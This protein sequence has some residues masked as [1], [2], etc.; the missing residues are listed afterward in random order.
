MEVDSINSTDTDQSTENND[1]PSPIE[2]APPSDSTDTFQAA[3]SVNPSPLIERDWSMQWLLQKPERIE[4]TAE[5][6]KRMDPDVTPGYILATGDSA[7]KAPKFI[8]Y[9]QFDP[10]VNPDPGLI[11]YQLKTGEKLAVFEQIT[12]S[13]FRQVKADADKWA[14]INQSQSNQYVLVG[15]DQTLP[16]QFGDYKQFDPVPGGDPSIIQYQLKSGQKAVVSKDL[17][18]KFFEQVKQAAD[19]WGLINAKQKQ[20][21]KVIGSDVTTAPKREDYNTIR[22]LGQHD[23]LLQYET[24]EGK[25]VVAKELNPEMY[26][27][28]LSALEPPYTIHDFKELKAVVDDI[29]DP[30]KQQDQAELIKRQDAATHFAQ[31]LG[32][33]PDILLEDKDRAAGFIDHAGGQIDVKRLQGV[34]G[35]NY[36]QGI[37]AALSAQIN[38]IGPQDIAVKL[39]GYYQQDKAGSTAMGTLGWTLVAFDQLGSN[40]Q[41]LPKEWAAALTAQHYKNGVFDLSILQP[42]QR[43]AFKTAAVL[44]MK[45]TLGVSVEGGDPI[46][47][48]ALLV[49]E[50]VKRYSKALGS[51]LGLEKTDVSVLKPYEEKVFIQDDTLRSY[52]TVGRYAA[53]QLRKAGIK[54]K[55][56]SE[57]PDL[58]KALPT[59]T[60]TEYF[61]SDGRPSNEFSTSEY[62]WA[63]REEAERKISE[64]PEWAFEGLRGERSRTFD[65]SLAASR[66]VTDDKQTT[67]LKTVAETLTLYQQASTDGRL[68]RYNADGTLATPGILPLMARYAQSTQFEK[69]ELI[70]EESPEFEKA[71]AQQIMQVYPGTY[72]PDGAGGYNNISV[73]ADGTGGIVPDAK[74]WWRVSPK[75]DVTGKTD[76]DVL[77]AWLQSSGM[78]ADDIVQKAMSGM[79][80]SKEPGKG[81]E[82]TVAE[83]TVGLATGA[84]FGPIGWV[85]GALIMAGINLIENIRHN[86]QQGAFAKWAEMQLTLAGRDPYWAQQNLEANT[87]TAGEIAGAFFKDFAMDFALNVAGE[88]ILG[89]VLSKLGSGVKQAAEQGLM[90]LRPGI[91]NE[92]RNAPL[93]MPAIANPTSKLPLDN[94]NALGLYK[95]EATL[96][97]S[98][99]VVTYVRPAQNGLPATETKVVGKRVPGQQDRFEVKSL[100]TGETVATLKRMPTEDGKFVWMDVE[101]HGLKGGGSG[102]SK[103][104]E[105]LPQP[106][107]ATEERP[108][109]G[110][111]V[112]DR[113]DVANLSVEDSL[114]NTLKKQGVDVPAQEDLSF[115]REIDE[116]I[117]FLDQAGR[118]RIIG[119]GWSSEQKEILDS[120]LNGI[121]HFPESEIRL[122]YPDRYMEYTYDAYNESFGSVD[123]YHAYFFFDEGGRITGVEVRSE[124]AGYA[125]VAKANDSGNTGGLPAAGATEGDLVTRSRA[126]N[127]PV[128]DTDYRASF[129]ERERF[130]QLFLEGKIKLDKEKYLSPDQADE[131]YDSYASKMEELKDTRYQYAGIPTD[132]LVALRTY[133]VYADELNNA[134][135]RGDLAKL[136]ELDPYIKTLVSGL[137]RLPPYRMYR[138]SPLYK[139]ATLTA[140][141]IKAYIPGE[142]ITEP[143]FFSTSYSESKAHKKNVQYQVYSQ[144]GRS[145]TD[146]SLYQDWEAE[147]LLRPG[148]KFK[149]S[150]VVKR[151]G[152]SYEY[153]DAIIVL[154]E[155]V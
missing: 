36:R 51:D 115:I 90:K 24:K 107:E 16:P 48:N 119:D 145:L 68:K 82:T 97:Y 130:R 61:I 26:K 5:T 155:V 131:L 22:P 71:N 86:E 62:K 93:H 85:A 83:W 70:G 65:A 104:Q 129:E 95:P 147:V 138:N 114:I 91:A 33:D 144:N 12:P 23:N 13:L 154:D 7:D 89:P 63:T 44:F 18:A 99:E 92:L 121:S 4:S 102:S 29:H 3:N 72:V 124:F 39:Q 146:I 135:K 52:M 103:P 47:R 73:I 108:S 123:T 8:D 113:V 53:D 118:D 55:D 50:A 42:E 30:V 152:G 112:E 100:D 76:A 81:I 132:E 14:Q 98:Y 34:N 122:G 109:T 134:F 64:S 69:L 2:K 151:P 10:P 149:V 84:M 35:A 142:E 56:G 20:G 117:I 37:E 54:M 40:A 110:N 28:A 150:R 105:D 6:G 75:L 27:Q 116:Q 140:D 148:T 88:K 96:P 11:Q 19:T 25:F 66:V 133:S 49:D 32:I 57:V 94:P 126:E 78:S 41:E 79:S 60:H 111:V 139:G 58:D 106:F 128:P 80:A 46:E 31:Q 9:K 15:N 143:A 59:S 74:S 43:T 21:Y 101:H 137:N 67:L 153:P 38:P 17:N 127:Y 125:T 1:Q 45:Q 77:A 87:K 136:A 120:A 141:Q